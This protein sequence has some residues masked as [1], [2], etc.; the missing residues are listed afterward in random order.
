L[1]ED[2]KPERV[3]GVKYTIK[4]GIVFDA[5]ELLSDVREIVRQAKAD[6]EGSKDQ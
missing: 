4:D 2:N 5:K 3:G 1:G 6:D